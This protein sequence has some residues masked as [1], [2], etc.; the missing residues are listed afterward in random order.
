[1]IAVGRDA[2]MAEKRCP[3]EAPM[4]HATGWI[5]L[6][7]VAGSAALAAG[8]AVAKDS[9]GERSTAAGKVLKVVAE[10]RKAPS[11]DKVVVKQLK[12]AFALLQPFAKEARKASWEG[13]P[14][15]PYLRCPFLASISLAPFPAAVEKARLMSI[16][17]DFVPIFVVRVRFHAIFTVTTLRTR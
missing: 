4:R 14:S 7:A 1:M 10:A 16:F 8:T 17:G 3:K 9:A 6:A 15:A 12:E 11:G 5:W 13:G 2:M